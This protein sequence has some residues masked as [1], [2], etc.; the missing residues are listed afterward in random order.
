MKKN[1]TGACVYGVLC[2]QV[3]MAWMAGAQTFSVLHT[4]GP[5]AYFGGI[6]YPTNAGGI[7]PCKG[8]ALSGSLLYG[9]A[10]SGGT[11]GSGTLYSINYT[12]GAFTLIFIFPVN[13]SG[14]GNSFG[15]SPNGGLVIS[16]NGAVLYGT[17]YYGGGADN[18][19]IF[20]MKTNGNATNVLHSFSAESNG[21]NPD[22]ANPAAGLLLSGSVLYGTTFNGGTAGNGVVFSYNTANS[23]FTVLHNF[24]VDQANAFSINTNGD[25]MNPSTSLVLSG[26]TLFGTASAGGTN[27]AGTIFAMSTNGTGFV[28]LHHFDA[29]GNGSYPSTELCLSG[30][31]LFGLGDT[32]AYSLNTDGTAFTVLS[33][34]GVDVDGSAIGC[35]VGSCS[36]GF[37][38]ASSTLYGVAANAGNWGNGQIFSMLT[39]SAAYISFHDFTVRLPNGKG[40]YT[41]TDGAFPNG[42]L[43]LANGVLYGTAA[44]GGLYGNGTIF[45]VAP[46]VAI[47]SNKV[48]NQKFQF[49]FQ[50]FGGLNY[51]VEQN[52][53]LAKTNWI[54][55]TNFNGSGSVTQFTVPVTNTV[56]R[57]FL[58]VKQQ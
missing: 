46:Q 10:N 14:T 51:T 8:L 36:S 27:G 26:T 18:G 22:G 31:K 57:L 50:T 32:A 7:H 3:L 38:V 13:T 4:F 37:T 40:F 39:N 20:S 16:N 15:A 34:F 5:S 11:N 23:N 45:K 35:T 1:F 42:G 28:V 9:T 47:F 41:N 48:S 29:S 56:P 30:G 6:L 49:F 17:T 58:R 21:S 25:G 43:F 52:T 54:T 2:L 19:V 53:N 12:N 24:S 44:S 55:F 33:Q